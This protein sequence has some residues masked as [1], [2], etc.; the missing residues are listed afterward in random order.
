[1]AAP[2]LT[3]TERAERGLSALVAA[4][5]QALGDTLD[6]IV[7]FGSAAEGR[8]RAASDVNVIFVLNRFDR[9]SVDALG[10]PR[11]LW[12]VVSVVLP[13]A[14]RFARVPAE[15]QRRERL[16][17]VRRRRVDTLEHG[18]LRGQRARSCESHPWRDRELQPA[19]RQ[20]ESE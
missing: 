18:R 2:A 8:L 10:E 7:L 12:A 16:H 9:A 14:R 11:V 17:R 19:K 1:M 4:A 20:R 13:V 5:R 3:T 15:E 6:S